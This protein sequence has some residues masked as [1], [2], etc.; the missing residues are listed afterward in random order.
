MKLYADT[1]TRRSRQIAGDLTLIAWIIACIWLA[2]KVFEVTLKLAGPGRLLEDAGTNLAE[3]LRDAGN[4]ADDVPLVGDQLAKP[5]GG[6]GGAASAIADAGRSQI[7]T[8]NTFAWWLAVAVA[9]VPILMMIAVY[10]PSRIRFIRRAGTHVAL[11][12]SEAG[13]DLLALRA[14]SS[15]SLKALGAISPDP[16]GDW[17]R[18]HKGAVRELAALELRDTG[19]KMPEL[20]EHD[21]AP[22][23]SFRQLR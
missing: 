8:V 23:D 11:R 7:E 19:L 10:V 4:T 21:D 13:I 5:F 12:N 6:A 9:V 3:K 18:G 17:R 20:V 2:R 15:Q 22:T 16:A 1:A 14:L